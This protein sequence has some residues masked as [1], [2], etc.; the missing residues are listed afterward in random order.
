MAAE[1]IQWASAQFKR[2]NK[3]IEVLFDGGYASKEVISAALKENIHVKTRLRGIFAPANTVCQLLV[4]TLQPLEL[5]TDGH[6][7][8][9]GRFLVRLHFQVSVVEVI[10]LQ[11]RP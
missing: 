3:P 4:V 6:S 10:P 7:V 8:N 11:Y 9:A 2:L 1:L 5:S